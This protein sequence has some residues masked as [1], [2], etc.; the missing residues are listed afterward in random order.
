M[1]TATE[2]TVRG[3]GNGHV[4]GQIDTFAST[5]SA[6]SARGGARAAPNQLCLVSLYAASRGAKRDVFTIEN[7]W[8]ESLFCYCFVVVDVVEKHIL[9]L[10]AQEPVLTSDSSFLYLNGTCHQV[11][12]FFEKNYLWIW[13]FRML[14]PHTYSCLPRASQKPNI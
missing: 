3:K 12:I 9:T 11:V 1:I 7:G 5:F 10:Y 13:T 14:V 8:C 6:G 2:D 4:S